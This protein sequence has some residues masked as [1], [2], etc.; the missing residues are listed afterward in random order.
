MLDLVNVNIG[1]GGLGQRAGISFKSGS[2]N[3]GITQV[4]LPRPA[5]TNETKFAKK[6]VRL[7][8]VS[9]FDVYG[10]AAALW[11]VAGDGVKIHLYRLADA[12][13]EVAADKHEAGLDYS[14]TEREIG[15]NA[16]ALRRHL[17]SSGYLTPED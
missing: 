11:D 7:F 17:R 12:L 5:D 15:I 8:D 14:L 16:S 10:V 1:G 6:I 13:L 9:G 4:N 2:G 3:H